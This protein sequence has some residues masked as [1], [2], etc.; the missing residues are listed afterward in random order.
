LL[1]APTIALALMAVRGRWRAP[2]RAAL[3]VL[4]CAA[5]GALVLPVLITTAGGQ[6][7]QAFAVVY[8]LGAAF[9]V[10]LAIARLR[11]VHPHEDNGEPRRPGAHPRQ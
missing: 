4:A 9:A 3:V 10:D 5:A 6:E 7:A 8:L 2:A 11:R 1:I